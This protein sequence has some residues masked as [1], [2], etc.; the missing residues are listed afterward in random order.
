MKK[1]NY[2]FLAAILVTLLVVN[3]QAQNTS[4][5]FESMVGE[6]ATYLDS[7]M[8]NKGYSFV[9][10]EKNGSDSYSYYWNNRSKKCITTRT[11]NGRVASIADAM[12]FD[13]GKTGNDYNHNDYGY[14]DNHSNDNEKESYRRGFHDG[15]KRSKNNPYGSQVQINAYDRGYN[16]G[17]A[18]KPMD[19]YYATDDYSHTQ[20]YYNDYNHGNNNHN[21]GNHGKY[22]FSSLQGM[23]SKAGYASLEQNGFSNTKTFQEDDVTYKLWYN[24]ETDQCIKTYSKNY[25]L[26]RVENSNN[27][28]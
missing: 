11:N 5:G 16:D 1:T 25:Y 10:N 12:P 28:K 19:S 6:K 8:K 15:H 9:K 17:Y 2:T 21:S 27:C 3:T 13:C 22:D 23:K 14:N 24:S 26:A 18:N 7:D 20:N 4:K